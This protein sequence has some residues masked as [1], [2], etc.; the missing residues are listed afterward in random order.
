MRSPIGWI[1]ISIGVALLIGCSKGPESDSG[2]NEIRPKASALELEKWTAGEVSWG[3]GN[4][5]DWMFVVSK[6][7]GLIKIELKINKAV[8]I[9]GVLTDEFGRPMKSINAKVDGLFHRW[10]FQADPG[11]KY[12][13][14]V[15]A[16]NEFD[17]SE[18]A[19]RASIK[20]DSGDTKIL[21]PE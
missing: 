13:V 18:Y 5:T 6:K 17:N 8:N 2:G 3:K 15:R 20:L 9:L 19:I 14:M 4:R 16:K 1:A 21:R 7:G 11:K 12:Y 10:V